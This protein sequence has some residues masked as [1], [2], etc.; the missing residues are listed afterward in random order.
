MLSGGCLCGD[1]RYEAGTG[2]FHESACHCSMCRRASGAPFVAWFSVPRANLRW[3]QGQ[4]R[5]HA[6]SVHGKR[7]FCP[8]CGTQLTFEDERYPDEVDL[9]TCSLDEPQRLPPQSHIHTA[10]QVAW[11]RLADGL[12]RYQASRDAG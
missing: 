2:A 3:L 9:T 7:S 6:S 1:V 8:R 11:L 10:S 4:A 5:S 12:P